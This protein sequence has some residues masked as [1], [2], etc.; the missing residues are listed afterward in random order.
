MGPISECDV[1]EAERL[2]AGARFC[3][4]GSSGDRLT[5]ARYCQGCLADTPARCILWMAIRLPYFICAGIEHEHFRTCDKV[6][7]A[8]IGQ[9]DIGFPVVVGPV[10]RDLASEAVGLSRRASP[11]AGRAGAAI[12]ATDSRAVAAVG[13]AD[14]AVSGFAGGAGPGGGHVSRASRGGRQ[15]AASAYRL[16]GRRFGPSRGPTTLGPQRQGARCISIRPGEY[17]QE[18][19]LDVISRR[20]LL[21]PGTGCDGCHTGDAPAGATSRHS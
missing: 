10:V 8:S 17:G 16:E 1:A 9:A 5:L 3:A 15:M 7:K 18:P 4:R 19:V 11:G 12:R 20:R 2:T 13:S 14:C 6:L 21:Q